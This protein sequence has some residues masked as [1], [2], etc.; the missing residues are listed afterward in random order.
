MNMNNYISK[1]LTNGSNG[2][3]AVIKDESGPLSK[4]VLL[5]L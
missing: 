1:D 2:G 3:S 5:T 4:L